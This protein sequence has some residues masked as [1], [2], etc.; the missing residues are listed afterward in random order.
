ME[1]WTGLHAGA[2]RDVKA[3]NLLGLQASLLRAVG[4]REA[5]IDI[6]YTLPLLLIRTSSASRTSNDHIS[7]P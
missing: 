4:A 3:A 7:T 6:V 1:L 2:G 5:C